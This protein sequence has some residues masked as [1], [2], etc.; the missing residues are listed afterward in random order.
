MAKLS[1]KRLLRIRSTKKATPLAVDL[2]ETELHEQDVTFGSDSDAVL[3]MRRSN[4]TEEYLQC[5][6]VTGGAGFVGSHVA[7]TLLLQGKKVVVYDIFNDETS[8]KQQK[9][10][11]VELLK[12]V[13]VDNVSNGASL[14]VIEGDVRDG[15]KLKEVIDQYNVTGC[16][17]LA[18]LVD[19]RRSVEFPEEYLDVNIVGTVTLLDTL[20]KCGVGMVVTNSTSSV[21]GSR[22]TNAVMLDES[23]ERCPINPYGA[24]KV[25]ADAMAHCYSHLHG[26]NVTNIRFFA[27]YG[28]RGRPDMMPRKLIDNIIAGTTIRKFGDGSATRSWSYVGDVVS[29]MLTALTQPQDG[30][31][32]FNTGSTNCT[33]LNELIEAAERTVGKKAVIETVPVPAGDVHTVGLPKYDK[34]QKV[35]GWTPKVGIV[36]GM[37][38]TYQYSLEHPTAHVI[39]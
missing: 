14:V 38:L 21:F 36:E 24:S 27:T 17:H 19:D 33:T 31:A 16:V 23:S 39:N 34:I 20:G 13:A 9:L 4:Y 5:V 26:M 3:G 8:T 25:A 10:E 37:Q 28:P 30:F 15:P 29:A 2:D 35:L 18:G 1:F 32:D 11:I 12:Q 7:E 6:L 22:P